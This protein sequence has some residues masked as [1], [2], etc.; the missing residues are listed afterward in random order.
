MAARAAPSGGA[1]R[2]AEERGETRLRATQPAA[3]HATGPV[4][5]A[6]RCSAGRPRAAPAPSPTWAAGLGARGGGA[7]CA[8]LGCGLRR[9]AA[10]ALRN[11][12]GPARHR[13]RGAT[14]GG[15]GGL[16]PSLENLGQAGRGEGPARS[17]GAAPRR[18]PARRAGGPVLPVAGRGGGRPSAAGP[19]YP[20]VPQPLL[21]ARGGGRLCRPGLGDRRRCAVAAGA[22]GRATVVVVVL[23]RDVGSTGCPVEREP[24]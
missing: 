10:A 11:G 8:A 17:P 18:Q 1:G 15:G 19:L 5:L 22:E 2:S 3:V 4:S 12:G 23:A 14:I 24:F 7:G 6:P 20:G 9:R 16:A 13:R 21:G